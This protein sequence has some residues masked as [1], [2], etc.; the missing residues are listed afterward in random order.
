M[1]DEL[2]SLPNIGKVLSGKLHKIDINT[3][4][5]FLSQDPY[6]VFYELQRKVDP[7]LCRC[8]LACII[9]AHVGAP[10]HKITKDTAKEYEKRHSH[11]KWTKC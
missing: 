11:H 9:G 10:W 3:K 8:A 7:T 2:L 4:E 5:D 1:K 6:D